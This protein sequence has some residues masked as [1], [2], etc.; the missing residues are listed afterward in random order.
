MTVGPKTS[1]ESLTGMAFVWVPAGC[2][3]MGCG[4]WTAE[5]D[6][7]ERPIHHVCVDGFW[8]GKTEVT[9][10]QWKTIMGTPPPAF[11]GDSYPVEW[12]S[13]YEAQAFLKHLNAHTQGKALFRL[14]TETEWEY[15]CRSGGKPEKY[16]GSGSPTQVAW[17][18]SETWS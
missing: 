13:W 9:Q 18:L 12:V 3:P 4:A 11:R 6:P 10:G 14:P 1:S 17:Y 16:A 15:A 5:C 8:M 2:F 7:D